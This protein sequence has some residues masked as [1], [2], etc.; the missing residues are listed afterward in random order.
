LFVNTRESKVPESKN[1]FARYNL[2]AIN[3][4]PKDSPYFSII[5]NAKAVKYSQKLPVNLAKISSPETYAEWLK[6]HI[7]DDINVD[8]TQHK[9][10]FE[11]QLVSQLNQLISDTKN[12]HLRIDIKSAVIIADETLYIPSFV[13]LYGHHAILQANEVDIAIYG[14]ESTQIEIFDLEIQQPKLCGILLLNCSHSRISNITI[15]KSQDYGLI[16]RQHCRYIHIDHCQFIDNCRSGIMLH[17]QTHHIHLSHCEVT[18]IHHSS[19]WAAGIVVTMM[20]SVSELS[21]QDAFEEN[22]FYPK[23][24]EFKFQSVPYRNIIENCHIHHNQSSGIYIDGGNGNVLIGNTIAY[25][26]K[27][28][29]CL[30][31]YAIAN[32]VLYNT[33]YHNGYRQYQS[34]H[35]LFI[36]CVI[37]FGRLAD[38]SSVSKLPNISLDNAAY[39]IILKNVISEAAGDGIKI[40]RSGFRNIIGLN[41]ITDNNQGHNSTFSFSGILLGSAV[42]EV[43]NDE[44]GLDRLASIENIIFANHIYGQ[45]YFGILYDNES[46]YNNTIDNFILKQCDKPI[47]E[48]TQ[49]N[50]FIGNN[51]ITN[52]LRTRQK[53][54]DYF[55]S[56]IVND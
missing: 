22:Y 14:K 4:I 50:N 44:S 24:L 8:N 27:E 9:I 11:G 5:E 10:V 35:D 48:I 37:N 45:H 7:H 38:N 32:V 51:F 34:D 23:N 54:L 46:V 56:L 33:L 29:I 49:P 47:L 43:E 39:N 42:S 2:P 16:L 20:E 21:T 1:L 18:G 40:V 36:D 30:D 17:E 15:K 25:N 41:T 53:L 55:K 6:K 26:D 12:T 28:G 3:Q 13:S 19:N 52:K 31:F